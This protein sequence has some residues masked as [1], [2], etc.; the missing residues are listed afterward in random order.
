MSN[1]PL[2]SA[3]PLPGGPPVSLPEA[4]SER[5]AGETERLLREY[6]TT[7]DLALRD[8]LIFRHER[9][10]HYLARRFA[11]GSHTAYEDLAQV[12]FIGLIGAIDRFDSEYGVAFITFATP[13]IAG[14]MKHHLRSHTWSLK[15]P[16]RLQ[17]LGILLRRVRRELEGRLGRAPTLAE[18]ASETGVSEAKIAEALD[19]KHAFQTVSLDGSCSD[20]PEE[21]GAAC[22][23][24]AL[25]ARDPHLDAVE[26][27]E[28]FRHAIGTLGAR[29]Q[30]VLT[31]R[32]YQDASQAHVAEQLGVSQMQVSRLERRALQRL[33]GM[34]GPSSTRAALPPASPDA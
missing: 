28:V 11:R 6:A 23:W 27:E 17:A 7:Q 13:T 4:L 34:L 33:K 22:S 9:L 32:F 16:G 3:A 8:E 14:A 2:R 5:G 1:A 24:E 12:G 29:E 15:V 26:E 25:G 10:V 20:A 18:F 19:L 31:Q 21:E 30:F